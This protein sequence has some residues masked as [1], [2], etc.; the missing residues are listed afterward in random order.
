MV[1]TDDLDKG[2]LDYLFGLAKE[3]E[4][5]TDDYE[6]YLDK[7]AAEYEDERQYRIGLNYK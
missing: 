7:M 2:Y 3:Y 1:A 5:D 4:D 6:L